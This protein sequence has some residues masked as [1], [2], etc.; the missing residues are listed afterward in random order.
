[1]GSLSPSTN[2]AASLYS[3]PRLEF[4]QGSGGHSRTVA[5]CN[6]SEALASESSRPRALDRSERAFCR[7]LMKRH[8]ISALLIHRRFGWGL[9]SIKRAA[10]NHYVPEDEVEKDLSF[11]PADFHSILEEL[12]DDKKKLGGNTGT[13]KRPS[14]VTQQKPIKSV[15]QIESRNVRPKTR[16]Q[17]GHAV[18]PS[19]TSVRHRDEATADQAF[20]R[21]FVKDIPLDA[22]WYEVLKDA[23]FTKEKLLRVA[24]ISEGKI[25]KF[26]T[27]TFPE[28]KSLDRLLFVE[29]LNKLPISV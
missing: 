28:M 16:Q 20:L 6:K 15:P 17:K 14:T 22:Q 13:K 10:G 26:I 9:S 12:I 29:A 1:M 7:V 11:L 21:T 23:G 27:E 3:R 4:N 2:N 5:T 19:S 8:H 18:A 25:D 24:G